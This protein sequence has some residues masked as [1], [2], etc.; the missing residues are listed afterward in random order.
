MFLTFH[1][2]PRQGMA[3]SVDRPCGVLLLV[4]VF[5]AEHFYEDL[6]QVLKGEDVDHRLDHA[7]EEGEEEGVVVQHS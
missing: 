7:V 3:G 2:V 1:K 6:S 4:F 5:T